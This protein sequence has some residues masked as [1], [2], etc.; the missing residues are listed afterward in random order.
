[1]FVT[2]DIKVE[3]PLDARMAKEEKQVYN[4]IL[5]QVENNQSV[6]PMGL[7]KFSSDDSTT[8]A[9][10]NTTILNEAMTKFAKWVTKGGIEDEWDTY[11]KTIEKSGIEDNVTII[12]KGFDD[13]YQK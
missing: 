6:V 7:M 10:N 2:T 4:S 11:L 12:Q 13:F 3:L 9:N 8:L 1:M 5:A